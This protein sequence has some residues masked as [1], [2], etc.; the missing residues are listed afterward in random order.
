MQYEFIDLKVCVV[1]QH[2][3]HIIA[4]YFSFC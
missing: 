3:Q 4:W 2:I 1:Y